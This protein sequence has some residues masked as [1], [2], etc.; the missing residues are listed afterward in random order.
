M[1]VE[2]ILIS[3][4]LLLATVACVIPASPVEPPSART[5]YP[6]ISIHG[7]PNGTATPLPTSQK[8]AAL[9]IVASSPIVEQVNG[10][11]DWEAY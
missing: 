4:L 2:L 5:P 1:K 11:Q 10:S 9:D 7:P 3:V 6:V 8:E